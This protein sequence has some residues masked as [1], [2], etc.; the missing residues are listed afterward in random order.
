LV[1]L[2]EIPAVEAYDFTRSKV[3]VDIGGGTGSL[4]AH[5]LR[6][7]EHLRGILYD[8]PQVVRDAVPDLQTGEPAGRCRLVG[9]DF[10]RSVPAG[11][12]TYLTAF[13]L[14]GM[15]DEDA[16]RLLRNV[17]SVIPPD[18]ELVALTFVLPDDDTPSFATFADL[19]MLVQAGGRERSRAEF[20]RLLGGA[21]F[22]VDRIVPHPTELNVLVATPG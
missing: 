14:H 21:G 9:G 8:L 17:R 19:H 11:G 10:M 4:L 1:R 7:Y 6:T 3:V 18:G 13:V 22:R 5:V 2:F 16:A 20:D 12:D 15:T